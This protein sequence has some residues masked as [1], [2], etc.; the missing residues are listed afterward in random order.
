M[1]QGMTHIALYVATCLNSVV[2]HTM[3]CLTVYMIDVC[4]RRGKDP[5]FR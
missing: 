3:L 1:K 4:V 5:H 2:I